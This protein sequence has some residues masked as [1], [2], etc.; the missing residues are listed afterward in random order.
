MASS[1]EFKTREDWRKEKELEEARK[2]GTAEPLKDEDGNDINP[3]IPQYIANAPWYLKREAPGLKHQ[4]PQ[5][6]LNKRTALNKWYPRGKRGAKAKKYRKGACTNCG[7]MTHTAKF[8]C[9][10]PRA[11]GAKFTNKDIK[12]DEI[13]VDLSD[14][15]YDASRDR[16]N[17]YDVALHKLDTQKFAKAEEK[18]K[19][20]RAEALKRGL[21]KKKDGEA[22]P[23][24]DD[25]DSDD[26]KDFRD[27]ENI[28]A[29]KKDPRTRTTIRN[30]RIREDTAKYL[31]NLALSSAHYDAKTRS[32][33]E[34][35]NPEA[36]PEEQVY[37]GDNAAR[38]TG[39]ALSFNHAQRYAW[40]A[41][42][43]GQNI[44]VQASP[45]Q[46]ELLYKQF[47]KK[48]E[49]L[50]NMEK[51]AVLKKYGGEKYLN[52]MEP[53]LVYAQSET[54]REYSR[55]GRVLKGEEEKFVAVSKYE[56]DSYHNNH[57]AIW[58]SYWEDGAWGF[59]CCKQLIFNS[60]CTGAAGK[61]AKE[62][63][64]E[65]MENALLREKKDSDE[66]ESDESDDDEKKQKAEAKSF[67]AALKEE[68]ERLVSGTQVDERSQSY[69]ATQ[70]GTYEVT[71]EQMEAYHLTK[72]H[73][74]DPMAKFILSSTKKRVDK[75]SKK[76]Q[77]RKE[78]KKNRKRKR[79]D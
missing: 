43:K 61:A 73:R 25:S 46:A 1:K 39:E 67:K 26:T 18:R 14:L 29:T 8:C 44:H 63:M 71:D 58:G 55:D 48:K 74:E 45:S 56:E 60:Y 3:H 54:Y 6:D 13:I 78:R 68:E 76:R 23:G 50:K 27:D 37:A 4:R 33:R 9:E 57:T 69:N 65:E 36:P 20:Q 62:S 77:K 52:S 11:K 75:R 15:D 53:A 22:M 49:A 21:S 28:I 42:E 32:M 2:A 79:N 7:A 70:G 31:R 38:S 72:L 59:A 47:K 41:Y 34:N 66:E 24:A 16:W 19:K 5:H 35:P 40:Q 64:L 51:S 12:R 10:R 30:L 17:G